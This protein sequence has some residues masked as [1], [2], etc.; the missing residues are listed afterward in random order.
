MSLWSW[1]L[2]FFQDLIKELAVFRCI[3]IFCRCSQNLHTHL[4]QSFR[5]FNGSLS[6]KLNHCSIRLLN[7]YYILNIFRSQRLE[8]QLICNIKVSTYC[9]RVI[10]DDNCLI[11]FLGKCPCTMYRAEVKLNTLTNTDRTG[12]KYQDFFLIRCCCSFVLC[13]LITVYGIII[14]CL[15]CKLCCTGINH[16]ISCF[17]SPFLTECFYLCLGLSGKVCNDIIREFHTFCFQKKLFCKLLALQCLLHLYQDRNLINKPPVNL[18]NIMQLFL[19]HIS[20]DS[21]CNLPDSA[22]IHNLQF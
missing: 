3:Y 2:A 20:A 10:V 19:R 21:L 8:I 11:S 18:G 6:T 5:Q 22:V 15:C 12:T 16:L 9:L 13:L 7:I 17:N 4:N 14:W 1:N